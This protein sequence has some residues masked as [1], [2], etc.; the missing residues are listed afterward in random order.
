MKG[1]PTLGL[2]YSRDSPFELVAY[3]D[4]DYAEATQDRKSTTRGCQFLGNRLISWQCKKQTV[5]A[6]STTEAEYVA[7]A[8]CC[9]QL[10]WIQ[11]QL[12]DY[13]YNFMHTVINIDNNSTIFIIENPVQHS[14]TK[15]IEIRH[16]FIRDCNAKKLIQMVKIHTDHNVIDLLTKGFD[17]GRV[18]VLGSQVKHIEYLMLNASPLKHVK[19]GRDTKIHQS[20]GPPVKVGDEA[21]HKELGDRMER[22]ATTASSLEAEQDSGSGPRCKDTILEDVDAQTRFE[23][24]SKQSNDPPL[25]RGYT[26]G[27]GEDT[28]TIN[29]T[30]YTSCIEQ[31]WAAAKANTVNGEHQ[32]QALV[33]RKRVIITES[34]IRSDL[35]LADAGV[36][37][38]QQLV[39]CPSQ[40]I[41]AN[42]SHTKKIFANMKREGNDFSGRVTHLF[43]TMMVQ[44]NQEE[45]VDSGIPTDHHQ[46]PITTQPSS[47]KSQKKQSKRKQRKD[48]TVTQEETQQDDSVPHTITQCLSAKTTAWN[49]FSSTMASTPVTTQP[50]S[51]RSQ[52]KQSRRKQRKDTVVTQE[53]TQQDDSVPI[54]SN[55]PLL[56]G[57][58]RMQLTELMILC[59]NLQKQVLDLEKAKD[60]QAKEI[61]GLKK[62][63]QKLERK[64]K[65]RTT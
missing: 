21:V 41:Y 53:E 27:S 1:K 19:R 15:H 35:H 49:E 62:R 17:A 10:L 23:T 46:T 44:P 61:V 24:T 22:A 36:F 12:L 31:F 29:P 8:S 48:T 30:I 37:I 3:T 65:S 43:A 55:D 45:G 52:K 4:S 28:L 63:V 13:G 14:K 54:P 51:Y 33:D 18:S 40:E 59:T 34:S 6:T 56:S 42:P 11:N 20:S 2:W 38:N 7:A 47:S 39:I 26:L 9:R 16:H 50:S 57:E 58:D 32:L 60:A 64:K 5:V 25:S